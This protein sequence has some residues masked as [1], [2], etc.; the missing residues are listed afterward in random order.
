MFHRS[1]HG[2][3]V[4]L[5]TI[6]G[7]DRKLVMTRQQRS[8]H[9]YCPGATGTGKSR[10]LAHMIRDHILT[11]PRHRC[12]T[13]VFDPHGSLFD[14]VIEW[15]AHHR[16]DR[17]I[18]PIDLRRNDQVIGYNLLRHR[19]GAQASVVIGEMVKALIHVF[20]AGDTNQTPL[21]AR[22][23]TDI[24][25]MLYEKGLSVAEAMLL[26]ENEPLRA[27]LTATITERF[28]KRDWELASK[29]SPKQ[30]EELIGSTVNR[31]QRLVR[32]ATLFAMFG[33]TQASLD[34]HAALDDGSIILVALPTAGGNI[35]LEDA[36]TFGT[37]L[38]T[39]LWAAARERGKD[40][41]G[42]RP[43]YLY[44]DE[45]QRFVTPDISEA[46]AEA[47][48]FGIHVTMAN[49]FPAQ[50]L[51]EGQ[52]GKKLYR[53]V[54][55]NARSKAVFQL[56][57]DENLQPLAKWLFRGTMN[58][59]E[60][61]LALYSTKV[62]GYRQ[63][64]RQSRTFGTTQTNG[65]SHI[66]GK[67]LSDHKGK[68]IQQFQLDAGLEDATTLLDGHGEGESEVE[69]SVLT[70]GSIESISE[71][72]VDVPILGKELSSVQYRSLDEQLHRAMAMLFEQEQR[73]FVVRL[74]GMHAPVSVRVPNVPDVFIS[75][76]RVEEYRLK[77]LAKLPYVLPMAEAVHRIEAREKLLLSKMLE[78][79]S[80]ENDEQVVF[81]R[82]VG[83]SC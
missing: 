49:Q 26:L 59:D 67:N 54:M 39:D 16:L 73:H 56:S 72:M 28:A 79:L 7:T 2:H 83:K 14:S 69:G 71:Q 57:D 34:L 41:P 42:S 10:F 36:N 19:S 76:E 5:G 75:P 13:I 60:I 53:A 46:L 6:V 12:G 55:E 52:T 17:P 9:F 80:P 82:N 29:L 38:L 45:F 66:K 81:R 27:A 47:R 15:C 22:W 74:E 51:D 11:W 23:A 8:T 70:N 48:G 62:M 30:L 33:Q 50:L 32:N 77:L 68:S 40:K 25:H 1:V 44:I 64:L 31:L 78:D 65:K 21:L 37:M 3:D 4:S 63:E 24:F 43:F 58:P 61:K 18:V 20:G 35:T